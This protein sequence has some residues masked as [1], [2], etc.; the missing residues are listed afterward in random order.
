M[1]RARTTHGE[2]EGGWKGK[3]E[4]WKESR[5]RRMVVRDKQGEEQERTVPVGC[6]QR[7]TREEVRQVRSKI[8]S[9][10]LQQLVLR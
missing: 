3:L 9:R 10:R 4:E 2:E 7:P 1:E 8:G 5:G 6:G